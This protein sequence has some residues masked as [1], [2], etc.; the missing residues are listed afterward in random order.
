MT[1]ASSSGLARHSSA[2]SRAL[3]G[4]TRGHAVEYALGTAILQARD[5]AGSG[6]YEG[7]LLPSDASGGSILEIVQR[8]LIHL[9]G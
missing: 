9:G 2:R 7:A 3:S 8:L 4:G 1:I 6:L 5:G